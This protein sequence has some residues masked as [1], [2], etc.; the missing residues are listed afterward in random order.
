MKSPVDGMAM[1]GVESSRIQ[2][3]TDHVG[4]RHT[5]RWT[6]IFFIQVGKYW[7]PEIIGGLEICST[8]LAWVAR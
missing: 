2:S 8:Q 6:E 5:I 3:S 7:S 1:D 4:E